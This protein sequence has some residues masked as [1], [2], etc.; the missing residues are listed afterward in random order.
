[1]AAQPTLTEVKAQFAAWRS[2][3]QHRDPIPQE[4][5]D[6]AVSLCGQ[7]SICKISKALSLCYTTLKK[8]AGAVRAVSPVST[9]PDFIA[10][11]LRSTVPTQCCIEMEHHNGNKMRMHFDGMTELDLESI[12]ETFWRGNS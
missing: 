5:W 7:Y 11:D 2:K 10:V 6:A 3:K 1:M 4:L 12:A 8:R 9:T